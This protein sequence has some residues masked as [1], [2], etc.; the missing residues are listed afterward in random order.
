MFK[1]KKILDIT[2]VYTAN[3]FQND[4]GFYIGAG[5]EFEE[6]EVYLYDLSNGESSPIPRQPGGMMSFIPVPGKPDLF[7]S[8][9]GFL[10]GFKGEEAGVY[11][12]TRM[13]T[14][15]ESGKALAL[16]FAHCCETFSKGGKEYLISASVSQHK[17]SPEDWSRPGELY[18]VDLE[19]C[20]YKKWN[21]ELIDNS[22]TRNH[23]MCK[24]LINGSEVV[25]VC[26]TEGIFYIDKEGEKWRTNAII[27]KEV[28]EMAFF[29]LDGDGENELVT[30]EPFHGNTLNIYKKDG[31][32][33][34]QKFSDGLSFGHGLSAGLFK[35]ERTIVAGNR[36]DSLA[37][38]AF[39]VKDLLRG[40]IERRLI[41]EG[42]GPTQTQVFTYNSTDYI[43]SANQKKNEVALYT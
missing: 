28:S 8:I 16:P 3:A 2:S 22:I 27:H 20:E 10:P 29:D 7:I 18:V 33:W 36:A 38:E 31:A 35:S 19:N 9:M 12:H 6:G 39:V 1:K 43:L 40:T 13:E 30:I 41:E 14:N 11:L 15:W 24:T 34:V 5:S 4:S 37:L 26:G 25:C 23:G 42:V 17:D 21:A 32:N